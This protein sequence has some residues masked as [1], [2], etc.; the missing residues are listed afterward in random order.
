MTA[1]YSD[2]GMLLEAVRGQMDCLSIT[3]CVSAACGLLQQ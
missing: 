1:P 2:S 3:V